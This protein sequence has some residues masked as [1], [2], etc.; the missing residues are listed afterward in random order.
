[1][2]TELQFYSE[3]AE[4]TVSLSFTR[5]VSSLPLVAGEVSSSM[6]RGR[7]SFSCDSSTVSLGG[8][9]Y[10][11]TRDVHP[12]ANPFVPSGPCKKRI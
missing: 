10:W 6:T 2:P 3:Q 7:S 1:M 12:A 8:G 11:L 5:S 9:A 4:S